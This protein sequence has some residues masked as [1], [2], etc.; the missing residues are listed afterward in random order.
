MSQVFKI[1]MDAMGGDYAPVEQVT[2]AVNA[3]NE[4]ENFM[5]F[6]AGDEARLEAELAKYQYRKEQIQIVPTTEEISCNESPVDAIRRKK[7]SSMVV[8][9]RMVRKGEADAFISSGSSGAVLGGG[10]V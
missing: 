6:L 3:V 2:A 7:D 10:Q 9:L 5:M 1:A 4:Y 8:A